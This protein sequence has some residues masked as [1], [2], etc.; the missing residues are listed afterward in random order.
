MKKDNKDSTI[1]KIWQY[2]EGDKALFYIQCKG[3]HSGKPLITPIPNCF[4]VNSDIPHFFELVYAAYK[5]R[6]FEPDIIGSVVPYIRIG[7]CC[8]VLT[9]VF[10]QTRN[11]P[12]E[13][14]TA[15]RNIDNLISNAQERLHLFEQ[16]Q[17]AL[18]IEVLR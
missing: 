2:K 8:E 11:K 16:M 13:K 4:A 18:A 6:R 17:R 15:I 10:L 9:S 12:A 7:S 5:G 3:L 1:Y 14:L